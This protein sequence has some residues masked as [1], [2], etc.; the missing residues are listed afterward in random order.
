M[1]TSA[2][3][4]R[5]RIRGHQSRTNKRR[6]TRLIDGRKEINCYYCE[7]MF[8]A[9]SLTIE[10]LVPRSFGGSNDLTNLVLACRTCNLEKGVE[11]QKRKKLYWKFVNLLNNKMT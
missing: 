4:K 2:R 11:S 5:R 6:K 9:E 3:R 1:T 7:M 10:H 8:E